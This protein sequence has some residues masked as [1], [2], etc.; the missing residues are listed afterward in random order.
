MADLIKQKQDQKPT[1]FYNSKSGNSLKIMQKDQKRGSHFF[2]KLVR[3]SPNENDSLTKNWETFV[4]SI[5]FPNGQ[6]SRFCA[7]KP[8][9]SVNEFT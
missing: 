8:L 3:S 1:R 7:S 2:K 4:P 5:I 9:V 6:F